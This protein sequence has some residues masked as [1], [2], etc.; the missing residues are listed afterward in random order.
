[1]CPSPQAE[2]TSFYFD[3]SGFS[4]VQKSLKATSTSVVLLFKTLSPGGLLLYLASN[5]T[6]PHTQTSKAFTLE[7]HTQRLHFLS[8]SEGLPVSRTG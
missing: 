2:E 7:G 5:N 8:P 4:V 1:M 3:G 6:V